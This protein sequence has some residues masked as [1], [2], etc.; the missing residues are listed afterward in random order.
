MGA[1]TLTEADLIEG[2]GEPIF[3]P[4]LLDEI[5][6]VL[7]AWCHRVLRIPLDSTVI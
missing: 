6:G 2:W 7:L 1:D 3:L 4:E 5:Q